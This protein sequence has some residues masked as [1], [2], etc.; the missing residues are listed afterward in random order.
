MKPRTTAI[1]RGQDPARIHNSGEFLKMLAEQTNEIAKVV[2]MFDKWLISGKL[3]DLKKL[4][5]ELRRC[6][7][8]ND[9]TEKARRRY[10]ET[11]GTWK[12]PMHRLTWFL[13]GGNFAIVAGSVT[14]LINAIKAEEKE[15]EECKQ[16]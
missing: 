7:T 10:C 13:T 12:D 14:D 9:D 8:L 3:E 15:A 4:R 5:R 16:R 1:P 2:R 6:R 11:F